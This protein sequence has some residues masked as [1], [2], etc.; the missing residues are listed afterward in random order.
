MLNTD[1]LVVMLKDGL[2]LKTLANIK[3]FMLVVSQVMRNSVLPLTKFETLQKF[4]F[5]FFIPGVFL[6]FS[7]VCWLFFPSSYLIL[8][9]LWFHY[10]K[11]L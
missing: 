4:F 8:V 5:I 1:K 11:F 2:S 3:K 10:A 6:Q 7:N 9:K